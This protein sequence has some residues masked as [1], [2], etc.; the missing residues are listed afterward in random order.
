MFGR[1]LFV[2]FQSRWSQVRE[3][4]IRVTQVTISGAVLSLKLFYPVS[5]VCSSKCL[6]FFAAAKTYA[7]FLR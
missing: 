4:N 1:C 3:R 7:T 5:N 2:C 6:N